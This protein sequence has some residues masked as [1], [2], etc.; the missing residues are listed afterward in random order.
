MKVNE[1]K[2]TREYVERTE[3]IAEDGTIF[4]TA[5]ECKKYEESALFAVSKKLKRLDNGK[6]TQ[7][8]IYY[9]CNDDQDIDIFNAETEEDLDN[10]RRYIYLKSPDSKLNI[11]GITA[12]HEIIVH[13]NYDGDDAW[14]YGDGSINAFCEMIR[15]N[16]TKLIVKKES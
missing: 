4:N 15:N 13:W 16:L 3:Y 7:Y 6:A 14:T 1:I 11:E 9:E 12:G 2:C 5:E 10:I 8:D